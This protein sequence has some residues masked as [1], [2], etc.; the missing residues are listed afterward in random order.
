MSMVDDLKIALQYLLPG[1]LLSRAVGQLALCETPAIKNRLI[2][3]AMQ[4]F[5]IDLSD[6]EISDPEAYPHFNAFFTRALKA[7][8]RPLAGP[9]WL[10]SPADGCVYQAGQISSEGILSAKGHDFTLDSLFGHREDKRDFLDGA[11]ATI[12][13]SPKD[14]HRV[15]L[16][17]DG[18]LKRMTHVPGRLFSVNTTTTDRI[19]GVFAR[20]ERVILQFKTRHGPLVLV[21]V[22]AML[23][24]SIE[25]PWAGIITPTGR[26][27]SDWRYHSGPKL[28]FKQ[29][30]E[31]GRFQF[32]ST[33]IVLTPKGMAGELSQLRPGRAVKM[34]EGLAALTKTEP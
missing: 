4:R 1:H 10:A 6:A 16:P 23:V 34:G 19:P 21:L 26:G 12:Y 8:A 31:I 9:D 14:Y 7:E 2:R 24:A 17:I 5:Q 28:S 29:G 33:V 11:F 25:T 32:G 22:G 20:N 13:L 3:L 15:H 30:D 27:L 18:E